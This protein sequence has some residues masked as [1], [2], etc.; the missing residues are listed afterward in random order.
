[1]SSILEE[2]W[3]NI[4]HDVEKKVFWELVQIVLKKQWVNYL[5]EIFKYLTTAFQAIHKI[6]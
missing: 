3:D 4:K 5:F 2:F 1:M 6:S